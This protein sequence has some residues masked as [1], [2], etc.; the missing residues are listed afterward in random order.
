[1][2]YDFNVTEVGSYSVWF[3]LK[4]RN[5]ASDLISWRLRDSNGGA[6][7]YHTG[8]VNP[9]SP[10]GGA[11]ITQNLAAYDNWTWFTIGRND[12]LMVNTK[13]ARIN[14]IGKLN[15]DGNGDPLSIPDNRRLFNL[16]KGKYTLEI[17]E[18]ELN[19]KIDLIAIDKV[20]DLNDILDFQPDVLAKDENNISDYSRKIL[21]YDIS[22]TLGLP[23][24]QVATFSAEVKVINNGQS[25][26]FRN[27]RV[28]APAGVK[29]RVSNIKVYI[30]DIFR[31]SDLS[32][33][34]LDYITGRDNI[35]TY[36]PL[37]ALVQQGIQSDTFKFTF[38]NLQVSKETLDE[39]DPRGAPPVLVKGR[40]C[41]ELDL[42]MNTVKPILRN[43]RLALKEELSDFKDN[44]PGD[45]R[46][47]L[48]RPA[49]YQCMS[50]HNDEHPYFKM[51]TFDYPEILC[52]Q[53][54]SRVNFDN[55]RQSLLTR[56][57][58]G[59]G[60]HP[61]LFF[62][63]DLQYDSE[64]TSEVTTALRFPAATGNIGSGISS[65]F[66][67]RLEAGQFRNHV[68]GDGENAYFSKWY[69]NGYYPTYTREDL[70]L[71]NGNSSLKSW[72]QIVANQNDEEL[73]LA[74]LGQIKRMNY[75]TIPNIGNVTGEVY[76]AV[77]DIFEPQYEYLFF[78]R[79]AH[80]R[81]IGAIQSEK[82][83]YSKASA[84]AVFAR[85]LNLYSTFIPQYSDV[86][87]LDNEDSA[88]SRAFRGKTFEL[89]VPVKAGG[90]VLQKNG[91]GSVKFEYDDNSFVDDQELL[92]GK[93]RDIILNWIRAEHDA[94]KAE[95]AAQ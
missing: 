22:K 92:K 56:G 67:G 36:A 93:Y 8:I 72:N 53:A 19:A 49:L 13:T 89:K 57:L 75:Q 82:D 20:K 30:N 15:L 2:V 11:C 86:D 68:I 61:K 16:T 28:K 24:G 63:E 66:K 85:G 46:D 60:V 47:G 40:K 59:S 51:T 52:A 21:E 58:D 7:A 71:V 65:A 69:D 81:F 79:L 33:S 95:E 18:R 45:D 76:N 50:C 83:V 6:V 31:F 43:A 70:G 25:Y 17:F 14:S 4:S 27:P 35:L 64:L 41:R 1:L 77:L 80:R 87:E 34:S 78:N 10:N 39:V 88:D 94:K 37:L 73:A 54:L 5:G 26:V 29:V 9:R 38:E 42:F 32:W 90:G 48:T 23:A 44:Y 62:I 55:Y 12:E 74:Y 84:T 3:K 91:D